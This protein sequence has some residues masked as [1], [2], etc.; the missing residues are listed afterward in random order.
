MNNGSTSNHLQTASTSSALFADTAY[1][2]IVEQVVSTILIHEGFHSSTRGVLR[3]IT[4]CLTRFMNALA[5]STQGYCENAGRVHVIPLDL[6]AGLS[7]CKV[8]TDELYDYLQQCRN[9][10]VSPIV[11]R[12]LYFK[13]N[14]F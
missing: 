3:V 2:Q 5:R 4:E 6:W 14:I 12:N 10:F 8:N 1:R 11:E 7:H 9:N 13:A